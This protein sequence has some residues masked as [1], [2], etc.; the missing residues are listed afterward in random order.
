MSRTSGVKRSP[1]RRG[2]RRSPDNYI[3]RAIALLL[4]MARSKRGVRL[5]QFA[6]ERGYPLSA[7]YRDRDSLLRAGVPIET[8]DGARYRLA[9]GWLPPAA[10]GATREDMLALFVARQLARG[11]RGTR[12]ARQLDA[13]WSKL[14]APSGQTPIIFSDDTVLSVPSL[15]A[16]DYAPHTVVIDLLTAAIRDRRAVRIRYRKPDGTETDRIIEPG[17]LHWDGRL[18]ALY[19][20]AWCRLRDAVRVFAVHRIRSAD[21]TDET[22]APRP[23]TRRNALERAYQIWIRDHVVP[24]SIQFSARVA[25]EIRERRRHAS[26]RLVELADGGVVLHLEVAEPEELTRWILGFGPDARVLAPADLAERVQSLHAAAASTTLVD[27]A[28]PFVVSEQRRGPS[29]IASASEDT[30]ADRRAKRS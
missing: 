10:L 20:P 4:A 1:P 7:V 14:A 27:G 5:R 8:S 16:I 29:R 19:V 17:F 26:Q 24:V 15:V 23:Q 2:P 12:V 18:E 22:F 11:L 30:D 21:T 6:D 13:L 9:D 3:V 28:V 25:G